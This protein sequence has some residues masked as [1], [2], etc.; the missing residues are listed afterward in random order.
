MVMSNHY[1]IVT[2]INQDRVVVGKNGQGHF[3]FGSKGALALFNLAS[4]K[5]VAGLLAWEEPLQPNGV[6]EP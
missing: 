6:V 1:H 4:I 3:C 2:G 5:L